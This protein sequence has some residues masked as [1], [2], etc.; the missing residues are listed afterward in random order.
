[1]N[2]EQTIYISPDD[3]LTTVRERLEQI[4]A[5]RLTM[6]IPPQTQLR[7]HVAW[8]LL[9]ARARELGKEVIIV[10]SDP[11]VRSVAH[12][13][14]FK[15]AHSLETSPAT[16][17]VRP[18]HTGNSGGVKTRTSSPLSS[19]PSSTKDLN[20]SRNAQNRRGPNT[21]LPRTRPS[22]PQRHGDQQRR[23]QAEIED[24]GTFS[25]G[26]MTSKISHPSAF[27]ASEKHYSQPYDFRIHPTPAIHPL[28]DQIEEPDLL[29]EDYTQAQDIRS[30]AREGQKHFSETD[31]APDTRPE[32]AL[33]PSNITS[34]PYTADDLLT[35][36]EDSQAPQTEQNSVV[37][38]EG[39]DTNEHIIQDVGD[40]EDLPDSTIEYENDRNESNPPP[41][42]KLTPYTEPEQ[43]IEDEEQDNFP[44]RSYGVR[45]R[46]RSHNLPSTPPT[47]SSLYPW[48]IDEDALPPVEE[49]QVP[50]RSSAPLQARMSSVRSSKKLP[51]DPTASPQSRT[52]TDRGPQAP[53]RSTLR[54]VQQRL[55][56]GEMRLRTRNRQHAAPEKTHQKALISVLI[57]IILLLFFTFLLVYYGP[58]AK[59]AVSIA[60]QDYSQQVTLTAKVGNQAQAIQAQQ[61]SKDFIKNGI[62]TATGSREVGTN[63]AQGI[64]IFTYNGS[65]PNGIIIPD[66][67]IIT[68][69]GDNPI[70]FTTTAEVLVPP[71][72]Q[73]KVLPP[74]SIQAVIAGNDGNVDA[75]T[76]T[77]IPNNTLNNIAQAQNPPIAVSDLNLSVV[78]EAPTTG[79]GAKP[80]ATVTSQD[81]TNVKN[82]LLEQLQGDINA[83][84]QKL[85][86]TG[87]VGTPQ[88]TNTLTNGPKVD[89]IE[90]NGTFS[91]TIKATVTIL[92]VRIADLQTAAIKQLNNT[93]KNDK[94]YAGETILTDINP[95]VTINQL[96][97]ISAD[98]NSITLTFNATA[99]AGPREISKEYIRQLVMG[100]SV[101]DARRALITIPKVK[102]VDITVSPSFIPW[103][104][105]WDGHINVSIHA[106]VGAGPHKIGGI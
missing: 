75:N 46:R 96:K 51:L 12:A 29:L 98:T 76:I 102:K 104:T 26:T 20:E 35:N 52:S 105:H 59:I 92:V 61:F 73:N 54:P 91:A 62:G 34:Q 5:K 45:S 93:I 56:H 74:V 64:V 15:V 66:G 85:S 31:I 30:A 41:N 81:L 10:S 77:V 13:V 88:I 7:S 37:S 101:F 55:G 80:I 28:S 39:I 25:E 79:G 70:K 27:D 71:S 22:E 21:R 6:V 4:S 50:P 99:Q 57:G 58:T 95:A 69:S 84:Q 17:K 32:E 60:T 16:G 106:D 43:A 63:P 38:L 36:M 40:I 89:D 100:K 87:A 53:I 19:H 24:S 3:D 67:S 23:Q 33:P 14:K 42:S 48:Q 44:S 2:D 103:V 82:N 72:N 47:P 97:Q 65:S 49:R 9:Y 8:K 86:N 1:M 68:T 11:Q 18:R 83:W 94:S 90:A 78:N